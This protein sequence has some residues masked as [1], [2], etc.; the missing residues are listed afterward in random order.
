MAKQS[1][2]YRRSKPK[3]NSHATPKKVVETTVTKTVKTKT[4]A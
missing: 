3:P 1:V 2:K 4:K